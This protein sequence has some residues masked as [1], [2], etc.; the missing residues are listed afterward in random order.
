[1]NWQDIII[2]LANL[3]FT[4]S[5]LYQVVHGFRKRKGFLTLTMSGLT[6]FGLYAV[7]VS[8]FT[9]R[10]YFSATVATI[11][12][13]LWLTLFIQGLIYEKA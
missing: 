11:N 13:T 1:M 3:L 9:L 12:A 10:L 7:G 4:Y 5:L 6:A 2:S 8:F